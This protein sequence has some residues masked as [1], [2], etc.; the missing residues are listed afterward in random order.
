MNTKGQVGDVLEFKVGTIAMIVVIIIALLLFN[1]PTYKEIIFGKEEVEIGVSKDLR[2]FQV[3]SYYSD[4]L[5]NYLREE[6]SVGNKGDLISTKDAVKIMDEL[7]D[8]L[9]YKVNIYYSDIDDII[10]VEGEEL[11]SVLLPEKNGGIIKVGLVLV[12]NE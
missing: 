1:V 8:D 4:F 10:M 9:P 5:M 3:R 11:A 2:F 6:S 12:K 7:G